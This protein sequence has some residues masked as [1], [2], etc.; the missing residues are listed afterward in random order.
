[1]MS[2]ADIES[3]KNGMSIGSPSERDHAGD[4]A[5][6]AR[7]AAVEISANT[8]TTNSFAVSRRPRPTG[9]SSR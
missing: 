2:P 3:P 7:R 1:M 4:R 5:R 6:T 9:R 8:A